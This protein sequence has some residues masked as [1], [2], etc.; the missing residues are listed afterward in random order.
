MCK[1]TVQRSMMLSHPDI[2]YFQHLLQLR[3]PP[4]PPH[5]LWFPCCA[6]RRHFFHAFFSIMT[7]FLYF[8]LSWFNSTSSKAMAVG[9]AGL[10]FPLRPSIFIYFE[11]FTQSII[12]TLTLRLGWDF[13]TGREKEDNWWKR[14]G[15]ASHQM[16][17]RGGKQGKKKRRKDKTWQTWQ[18]YQLFSSSQTAAHLEPMSNLENFYK[19]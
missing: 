3:K 14:E 4:P 2:I 18:S 1:T 17:P 16:R 5:P 10:I 19:K 12:G 7:I 15:V 8:I 9:V 13:W 6:V 11:W